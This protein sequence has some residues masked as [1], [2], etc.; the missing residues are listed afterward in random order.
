[1][2]NDASIF[3]VKFLILVLPEQNL[4]S[5]AF[6]SLPQMFNLLV[7]APKTVKTYII[8]I[9]SKRVFDVSVV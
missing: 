3:F 7:L 4:K 6:P 2:Y 1:M 5:N 8:Y 9:I